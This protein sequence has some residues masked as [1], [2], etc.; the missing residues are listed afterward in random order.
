[1]FTVL[2]GW[3]LFRK[4]LSR[5]RILALLLSTVGVVIATGTGNAVALKGILLAITSAITYAGYLIGIERTSIG[6]MDSMK[7]MFYM[8]VVNAAAVAIFDL[9]G[10]NIVYALPG[11]T[12]LYTLIMAIANSVF[13][14]VLLIV[15]I[16]LIGAGNAAIFSMME[17][18]SGVAAGVLFLHEGLPINKLISCLLILVAVG[19]PIFNDYRGE[20][21]ENEK[22]ST[23]KHK[24]A[25]AGK[26]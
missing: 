7:S 24:N 2:F 26:G 1:M 6:R 21:K 18:V 15:G 8:C 9:P 14:Y 10:G 20:R 19:I 11:K 12:F 3:L 5:V 17:P 13:A 25:E 23:E 16:K 22:I 4:K